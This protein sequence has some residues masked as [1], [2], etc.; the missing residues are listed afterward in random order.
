MEFVKG[1][2]YEYTKV[3]KTDKRTRKQ[4]KQTCTIVQDCERFVVVQFQNYRDS[5]LKADLI[6]GEAVL[7]K[8]I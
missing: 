6:T 4:P 7:K 5:I 2:T 8:V 1:D 3:T